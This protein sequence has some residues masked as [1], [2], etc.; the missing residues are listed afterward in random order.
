M[1]QTNLPTEVASSTVGSVSSVGKGDVGFR[2]SG[3][4]DVAGPVGSAGL[5][6]S[7]DDEF[8]SC[9]CWAAS[10]LCN[11]DCPSFDAGSSVVLF[12]N[13]GASYFAGCSCPALL[14]V[15][16]SIM[17]LDCPEVDSDNVGLGIPGK[18]LEPPMNELLYWARIIPLFSDENGDIKVVGDCAKGPCGSFGE[19]V[20]SGLPVSLGTV[21]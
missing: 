17:E 1:P 5:V 14:S 20:W 18:L 21:L 4:T 3:L 6:S 19:P 16:F 7:S 12:V 8:I 11:E 2:F 15:G 13:V 9:C 10:L